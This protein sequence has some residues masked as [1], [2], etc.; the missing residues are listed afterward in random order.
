MNIKAVYRK[1]VLI[2][3]TEE[4]DEQ[5]LR[6]PDGRWCERIFL[7]W[8]IG[9]PDQEM[10]G[11]VNLWLAEHGRPQR[12]IETHRDD[13][14]TINGIRFSGEVFTALGR[15]AEIGTVLRLVRRDNG[16]VALMEVDCETRG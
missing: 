5:F 11:V 10:D 16:T 9:G 8:E 12:F 1:E 3:V 7:S 4:E 15:D 6:F 14:V 13:V 2:V